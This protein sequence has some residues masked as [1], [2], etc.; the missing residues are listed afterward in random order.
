VTDEAGSAARRD[1]DEA[2]GRDG[3]IRRFT[4]SP[5]RLVETREIYE[6]LG[7][8]VLLDPVLPGELATECEGCTLALTMFRVIYTR[9]RRTD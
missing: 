8:D 5:P 6:S 7:L 1:R 2:L 9:A 3:W 4:G